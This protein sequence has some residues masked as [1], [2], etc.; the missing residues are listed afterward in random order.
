MGTWS[1]SVKRGDSVFA[2]TTEPGSGTVTFEVTQPFVADVN[3]AQ[4]IRLLMGSA[5]GTAQGEQQP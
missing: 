1:E 4:E 3:T 2:I 5:I